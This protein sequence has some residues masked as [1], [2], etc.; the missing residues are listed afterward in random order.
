M[1]KR[2]RKLLSSNIDYVKGNVVKTKLLYDEFII[3]S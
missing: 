2:G 1:V 3:I